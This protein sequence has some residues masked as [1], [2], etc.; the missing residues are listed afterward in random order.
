MFPWTNRTSAAAGRSSSNLVNTSKSAQIVL[1]YH[2]TPSAIWTA[3]P[4]NKRLMLPGSVTGQLVGDDG[5]QL[6]ARAAALLQRGTRDPFF[7]V[8][9]GSIAASPLGRQE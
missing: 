7:G 8:E 1:D 9:T 5:T 2:W 6:G 3:M 4:P